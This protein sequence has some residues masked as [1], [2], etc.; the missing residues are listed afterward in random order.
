MHT[1]ESAQKATADIFR[2]EEKSYAKLGFTVT[3][4]R[5]KVIQGCRG[6][7]KHRPKFLEMYALE[8]GRRQQPQKVEHDMSESIMAAVAAILSQND[9]KRK[10]R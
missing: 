3:D 5:K 2:E 7:I 8:T 1:Y 6:P 4:Y 10:S 9:P